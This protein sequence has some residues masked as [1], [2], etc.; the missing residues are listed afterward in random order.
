MMN[1]F[2]IALEPVSMA[3]QD[4]DFRGRVEP[5]HKLVNRCM[6]W[7][8]SQIR[9]KAVHSLVVPARPTAGHL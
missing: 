7:C 2:M 1:S 9:V 8:Q 5:A 6:Q 4:V 3:V